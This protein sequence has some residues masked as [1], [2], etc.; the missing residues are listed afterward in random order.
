HVVLGLFE[1]RVHR[2]G[3]DARRRDGD[4][5]PVH[6]QHPGGKEEPLLEL[7]DTQRV[8]E[9][10][11]HAM[12]STVPPLASIA[13]FA[14][15]LKPCALTGRACSTV[16]LPRILTRLLCLPARPA[17]ASAARSTTLPA[18]KR[19]R[20]ARFTTSN[21]LRNGLR[22]PRFGRRRCSG[23]WPPS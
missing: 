14:D 12:T 4:P 11:G 1:E 16:P 19:P 9:P 23:I 21:S 22:K 18:A 7:L 5:D 8:G 20:L 10:G 2:L 13:A 6:G 17:S 3:V 15:S